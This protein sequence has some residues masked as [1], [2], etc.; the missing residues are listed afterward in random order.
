MDAISQL[1]IFQNGQ[2]CLK[3]CTNNPLVYIL[4]LCCL[5]IDRKSNMATMAVTI[6]FLNLFFIFSSDIVTKRKLIDKVLCYQHLWSQPFRELKGTI[7]IRDPGSLRELSVF[8]LL[9]YFRTLTNL[10]K[11]CKYLY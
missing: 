7:R 3:F 11:I 1:P 6:H 8:F 10:A 4:C 2:I 5:Q 9:K